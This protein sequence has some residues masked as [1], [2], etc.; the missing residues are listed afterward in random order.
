M[1]KQEKIDVVLTVADAYKHRGFALQYN[2]L[3]M[4]RAVRCTPRRWRGLSPESATEQHLSFL[5]CSSFVWA[6]YKEAFGLEMRSDLTWYMVDMTEYCV[7]SYSPTHE[8]TKEERAAILEKMHALLEAGDCIIYARGVGTS[9]HAMLYLGDDTILHCTAVDGRGDYDY[10]TR[11]N[12]LSDVGSLKYDPLDILF[13]EPD[14]TPETRRSLFGADKKCFVVLRPLLKACEPTENTL[15][16]MAGC[17]KLDMTVLSDPAGG[18]NAAVGE[19][20]CYTLC[21]NNR[22]DARTVEV[23]FAAP[24]GT[25]PIGSGR[26]QT[27]IEA[28]GQLSLDF[29]VRVESA[30]LA[31]LDAPVVTVN[32]FTVAAPHISVGNKPSPEAL[33]R[34]LSDFAAQTGKTGVYAAAREAYRRRGILLPDTQEEALGRLFIPYD[35]AC[36]DVFWRRGQRPAEDLAAYALFGGTG[37][38]TPEIAENGWMRA[39]YLSRTDLMPGDLLLISDSA[40]CTWVRA[41]FYDG[42]RLYGA[43]SADA[44]E[45]L[46]TEAETVEVIDSL[47]GRTVFAVLRP[48][49]GK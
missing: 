14:G 20:I 42:R 15:R 30:D 12:R 18:R 32:G 8:E 34:L 44:D 29:R 7:F 24:K 33:S 4:D 43:F 19:E 36:G 1:T 39:Q 47:L 21:L 6:V 10:K 25:A 11:R 17:R 26:I 27:E 38:I 31:Q 48:F 45:R 46:L 40:R 16:R 49:L 13:V 37:V 22:G 3:S 5:D 9:G 35:T 28:G 23:G 2:Q 41:G